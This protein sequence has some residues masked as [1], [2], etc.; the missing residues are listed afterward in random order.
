[1]IKIVLKNPI[2]KT[3]VNDLLS[4]YYIGNVEDSSFADDVRKGLTAK[5]KY[6]LPKYFYNKEGSELFEKI[7]MTEEYYVTRTESSILK[8]YTADI[9]KYNLNKKMLMELGSGSSVK[10]KYIINAL[11]E[12]YRYLHYVPIDV[13]DIMITSSKE[14]ISENTGLRISAM[15]AEYEAG[16]N[17]SSQLF[18]ELKLIL[19][20]GSSI[21]NFDLFS[22]EQF[23]RYVGSNMKDGDS[24][25]I[26]FDMVKDINVLNS[27]Y[28]DKEGVTAAFNLNVL[29]RINNELGGNFNLNNFEHLAFFNPQQSRIE[30]HLVSKEEQIISIDALNMDVA[31]KA[32]ERIHTENSYKFSPEMIGEIA[33]Y[34]GLNSTKFWT[35]ENKYFRLYLFSKI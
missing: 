3:I 24:M 1:M 34:S 8:K 5:N 18:N 4:V 30:M 28:N 10:T 13:S 20:L 12:N 26:G 16:I 23:I 17:A 2:R 25:L 22:A 21:G 14:L 6:L 33:A 7:C 9:A 32:G 11:I 35:D 31:F 19:F 15:M 27:A 29:K